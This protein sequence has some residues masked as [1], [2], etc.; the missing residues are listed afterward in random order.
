V[1]TYR[2]NATSTLDLTSIAGCMSGRELRLANVGTAPIIIKHDAASGTAANRFD[3][4]EDADVELAAGAVLLL[5]YDGPLSRWQIIGGAGSGGASAAGGTA[6]N[7]T[8]GVIDLDPTKPATANPTTPSGDLFAYYHAGNAMVQKASLDEIAKHSRRGL[9]AIRLETRTSVSSDTTLTVGTTYWATDAA[10]PVDYTLTL[11]PAATPDSA[12]RI[13]ILLCDP[14]MTA[15]VT[16]DGDA[17]DTIDG[18]EQTALRASESLILLSTGTEWVSVSRSVHN[19]QGSI[20]TEWQEFTPTIHGLTGGIASGRRRRVG[21]SEQIMVAY[22]GATGGS[23]T[24]SLTT[25]RAIDTSK[26][27]SADYNRLAGVGLG[28]T[29]NG[30]YTGSPIQG[31]S[32]DTIIFFSDGGGNAAWTRPTNGIAELYVNITYPVLGWEAASPITA[33]TEPY[34]W[35]QRHAGS[36]TRVTATPAALGEYRTK[37]RAGSSATYSDA[38][39]NAVPTAADGLLLYGGEPWATPDPAGEPSWYEIYVGKNVH[40][41]VAFFLSPG[42]TGYVITDIYVESSMT[43]GS[44]WHYDPLTGIINVRKFVSGSGTTSQHCG[45]LPGSTFA[46]NV[47]F[48]I[49]V[50]PKTNPLAL[51]LE[52]LVHVEA[53]SD[54]GQIVTA[55]TT[56]LQ[57]EDEGSDTHGAWS[58]TTFTAP[59]AGKYLICANDHTL[60][61]DVLAMYL[62]ING[63]HH[64]T[65]IPSQ[66]GHTVK[67][68]IALSAG[69]QV[70]FRGQL[71]YTRSTL[72]ADNRISITEIR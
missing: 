8:A 35:A 56:L 46:E 57:W 36:A 15:T 65:D 29:A 54:A 38:T 52:T 72:A 1:A 43:A 21:D 5:R 66:F 37:T 12:D 31:T 63:V 40:V 64:V 45:V 53:S 26:L 67:T 30:N 18:G 50:T 42:H 61:S 6:V 7:V 71:S 17:E 24:I 68:A 49:L 13:I 34:L 55:N 11:P 44:P 19:E 70:T 51:A 9:S 20:N 23:G 58:G 25:P 2:I 10:N 4:S 39:P 27:P 48:D 62:Y 32:P 69:D 16:L 22:E 33:A 47:Y 41:D 3:L 60:A 59:R 28:W 14:S